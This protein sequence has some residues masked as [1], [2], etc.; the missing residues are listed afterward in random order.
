MLPLRSPAR[1]PDPA[2]VDQLH[3]HG[4]PRRPRTHRPA[5]LSGGQQ[6]RV[7]VARALVSAPAVVFADEP[8]GN[9]DSKSGS[10]VLELLRRS[11][12]DF[13]QTVV[14]VTHDPRR[15]RLADRS[16][17][18]RR[19]HR[20]RRRG[21]DGAD[22]VIELMKDLE[23]MLAARPPRARRAQAARRA[24]RARG[25][26]RR[27]AGRRHLRLHGHDQHDLRRDLRGGEQGHRRPRSAEDVI[28]SDNDGGETAPRPAS[29][30]CGRSQAVDGVERVARA[31]VFDPAPSSARTASGSAAGGAP[32]FVYASTPDPRFEAF[33]VRRGPAP[34]DRRRGGDRLGDRR[35]GGL[36]GRRPDHR[37]GAAAAQGLPIVG[38]TQARGVARSAAPPSSG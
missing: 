13:G 2:W 9:L 16:R 29:R 21:R 14:M 34:A 6:Q 18:R 38:I 20:A 11:V 7:A 1:K 35:R 31:R 12:D 4:R 10:D 25:R 33:T 37:Q 8:T 27:R 15:R 32:N 30:S 28:D 19:P 17:A 23:L 24:D 26:P 3:R 36:R 5:E 22:D